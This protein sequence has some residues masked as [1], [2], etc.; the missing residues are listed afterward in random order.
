MKRVI[1]M[2]LPSLWLAC[3]GDPVRDEAEAALGPEAPGEQ[4]GPLH[5]AGQS[6]T[7]CHRDEGSARAFAVAGTIFA[8]AGER[9]G[10][11]EVVVDLSDAR[12]SRR[13][14]V[15]N[16]AGNFFV[17]ADDWRPV[18]PVRAKLVVG[19]RERAMESVIQREGSCA[20]CHSDP[21]GPA[22]AGPIL[23]EETDV[24]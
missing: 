17:A 3:A 21:R 16:V 8:R 24:R 10:A 19:G 18:W 11:E 1:C 22:S 6:C 9:R 13:R 14:A 5:R 4:P 20:T 23:A 7:T 2:M 15:T 12:G